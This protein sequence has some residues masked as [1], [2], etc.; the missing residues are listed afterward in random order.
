MNIPSAEPR[1]TFVVADIHGHAELLERLIARL[2]IDWATD[3]L[4]FLGDYVD[5]GPASRR[6]LEYV[7]ALQDRFPRVVTLCGNHDVMMRE[8][9]DDEGTFKAWLQMDAEPT[10]ADFC[11][12]VRDVRWSRFARAVPP[13]VRAF[14]AGLPYVHEN[15]HGRYVH[16]GAQRGADGQWVVDNVEAVAWARDPAF[17]Q[18][19]TGPPI[20]VGHTPTRKLRKLLGERHDA[21]ED[22]LVWERGDVLAI[23]C[24]AG[25]GGPLCCIELPERRVIYQHPG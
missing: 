24:G 21:P 25:D 18:T 11:P 4:V 13:S 16:G 2:P 14:L 22:G 5:R 15:A 3:D 19:Y 23:D 10:Y 12:G 7:I 9:L 20:V 17:F 6:V 1:R 8:A